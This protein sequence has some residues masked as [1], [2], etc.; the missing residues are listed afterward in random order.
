VEVKEYNCELIKY[1]DEKRYD[2]YGGMNDYPKQCPDCGVLK[3]REHLSCCDIEECPLC[4]SQLISCEC[5]E[6]RHIYEN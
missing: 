5:Q 1:G 6:G 4:G 3:G 2:E